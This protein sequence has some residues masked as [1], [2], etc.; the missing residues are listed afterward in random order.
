MN[1]TDVT[2]PWREVKAEAEAKMSPEQRARYDA[3]ALEADLALDLA[4]KVYNARTAAGLS[5]AQL[6]R[7][8][9]TTQSVI[10]QIEGGGQTPTV[11][12]L[13]RVARATGQPINITLPAA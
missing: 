10:S 3:A 13:A 8:M 6:A 5:Q 12:M 9:G 4:E 7:R 2:R 1:S 11:A